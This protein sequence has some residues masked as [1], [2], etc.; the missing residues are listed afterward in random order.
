VSLE[1]LLATL[2]ELMQVLTEIL[3]HRGVSQPHHQPVMD[4]YTNFLATHPPMFTEAADPL[5]ADWALHAR[6]SPTSTWLLS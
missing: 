6:V 2:N 3:M 1:Q 4:S 5:E